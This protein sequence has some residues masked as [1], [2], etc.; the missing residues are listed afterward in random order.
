[1]DSFFLQNIQKQVALWRAD[2]YKS[3]YKET[4]NILTHIKRVAFLH[5]P[6]I[7]ALETYIYL[8]EVV[9]NKP[10]VEVFRQSFE[11]EIELIRALGISDKEAFELAYDKK[12]DEKIQLIL[13]DKF[14][15]S[16]YANQ[17]YALTMGSG[18]TI[19][20]AVM[21]LYDFV[22][23]FYHNDDE[24]FAKNALVFAPDT[25]II[26]SLKE[27]K[28]FDYSRVLPK[29]YENIILNIKYHYL[30][31]TD[32]PLAPN[33]NYN[34]I[35]SNSQKIILKTRNGDENNATKRL[36]G[37]KNEL[38]KREVENMRLQAIR[39]LGSLQI[40]VDEAHHSYGKT[41]EG[42]LKKTRQT[43]DYLHKHTPLISVVNLTGTPYVNNK[44]ISD[45]VYHFG[46]KQGIEKGILKQVRILDYGIVRSQKFLEEVIDTFIAEY[47]KK[48]LEGRL[49]KIA[50]YA[51]NINDLQTDLKPKLERILTERNISPSTIL[52]YHTRA[53][54]NINDFRQLDTAESKKRFVLLV[55][56]G[57]EGWNCRSL[58]SVALYKKPKST[59]LVLQSTTRC[60][61]A[62]GDNSTRAHIFLSKENY[63][64]LDKELKNNFASSI[65]ELNTQDQKMVEHT[66]EVEKRKTIKVKKVLKEILAVQEANA[67]NIKVDFKKFKPERYQSF[68]SEGGIFLGDEGNAGYS[69]VRAVR[70]IEDKNDFTFYEI[71]EIINR[72]THL[73]CIV[74]SS[75]ISSSKKRDEFVKMTNENFALVPFIVQEI[76]KSAYK[77]EEKTEIVE[78]ELE[79]TK[80]FPF[81]ISV[82]Q[83]R[84]TLVV[85]KETEAEEGR[86][87]RIGFHINPYA[88]D[89]SDE[90]DLFRYLRSVLEKKETIKDIYFTGARVCAD[91]SRTDF[92]FEYWSPEQKRMG[93]YF[94]DFLIETSKERFLV[95]ET[96]GGDEQADYEANKKSYKG[97]MENL[98]NE[99]LAK[100][101]GFSD[102]KSINKNFEYHIIFNASLQREQVRLFEELKKQ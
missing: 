19:L 72:Y 32:T 45:V 97:K 57:T 20:M 36:F 54:E 84:N 66:L 102:F 93:R 39:Q 87:G 11:N 18:K 51:S 10:S 65:S 90:K 81:K 67:E 70:K 52:E 43:I 47:D 21:M 4:E 8:K 71:V 74:I 28:T 76:L 41:L 80:L 44:M 37:D 101:I 68:V 17:V 95:I 83:G 91:P 23:S 31:S 3:V 88:F 78:E 55:G 16:D 34:V 63:K 25:T 6:Q 85:Y 22:L 98:T 5:E 69:E 1:M 86:K 38:G 49:P 50:F 7:E 14:G 35:V 79:L 30:E 58:V 13:D 64:I 24:R 100:E 53:E 9:G 62:I 40:F 48:R 82:Q 46:L 15:T 75:I 92:Y 89:S 2:G 29:E 59:I 33:G 99:I 12:K 96:K 42:T 61:R 56:K 60:L 26:E 27:I 73:S 77:Y 94:P